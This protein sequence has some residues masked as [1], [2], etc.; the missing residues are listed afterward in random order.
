MR[1]IEGSLPDHLREWWTPDVWC[2]HS[3]P[4]WRRHWERTGIMDI[5]LADTM[6]DG[7]QRWLEWLRLIAPDN[8]VEIKALEADRGSHLGYVRLVGRRQSHVKLEDPIVCI[9][10]TGSGRSR[11]ASKQRPRPSSCPSK[12][13]RIRSPAD[14]SMRVAA[15]TPLRTVW[16]HELFTLARG[17]RKPS[18]DILGSSSRAR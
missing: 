17:I 13:R 15:F 14:R 2:L 3:A 9:P 5:D 10:E 1:E 16:P 11:T 18:F 7:W 8:E 4:W 6:P 12:E